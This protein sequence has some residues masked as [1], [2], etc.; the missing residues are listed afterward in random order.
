MRVL[1]SLTVWTIYHIYA[2]VFLSLRLRVAT[3]LVKHPRH[4][5]SYNP[6]TR[7]RPPY[8]ARICLSLHRIRQQATKQPSPDLLP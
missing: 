6:I 4:G 3:S 2:F 8:T 5:V 1:W 7:L